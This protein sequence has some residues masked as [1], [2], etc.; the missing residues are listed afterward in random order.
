MISVPKQ[1]PTGSASS[2]NRKLNVAHINLRTE[3]EGPH[4]RMAIWF[5][6][7][8]ILCRGC[9]NPGL[10]PLK[11][12]HLMT[13]GELVN[14]ALK[15]KTEYG[16]EGVTFLGG[17][18]T[19]QKNLVFLS[20]EI[21]RIKLGIILFTGRLFEE[22]DKELIKFTDL[23]VDGKFEQAL[24]NRSGDLIGSSNQKIHLVTDR[25]K[26]DIEWFY[27]PRD[28][29]VEVNIESNDD[30]LFTGGVF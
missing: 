21:K 30:I 29:T 20:R 17:E 10:Q 22:L 15:A 16:I 3:T 4:K 12:A 24:S 14:I 13:A 2:L 27:R 6:G 9:C 19:L 7:C 8:D 25:Y 28:L 26:R 23:I 11:T 1:A 18:P 5:Q